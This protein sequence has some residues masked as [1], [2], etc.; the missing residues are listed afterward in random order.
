METDADLL[1]PAKRQDAP[2]RI[3]RTPKVVNPETTEKEKGNS[4]ANRPWAKPKEKNKKHHHYRRDW[5]T[6][7]KKGASVELKFAAEMARKGA[8]WKRAYEFAGD[9]ERQHSKGLKIR[10]KSF[11]ETNKKAES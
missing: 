11:V 7:P 2:Y 5:I 6:A 1:T 9:M 8:M 4:A 10:D 3:P